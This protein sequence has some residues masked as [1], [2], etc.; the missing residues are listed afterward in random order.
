MD[1]RILNQREWPG[2][3]GMTLGKLM[4]TDMSKDLDDEVYFNGCVNQ[5]YCS[6]MDKIVAPVAGVKKVAAAHPSS[7]VVMSASAAT[8]SSPFADWILSVVSNKYRAS[9]YA[10]LLDEYGVD[11]VDRLRKQITIN[12]KFLVAAGVDDSADLSELMNAININGKF[13]F[14]LL[15]YWIS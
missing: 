13:T 2:A 14:I 6:I 1:K 15:L 10:Q 7:D 11:C 9:K 4:Y 12:P 3:I 5:L 8:S